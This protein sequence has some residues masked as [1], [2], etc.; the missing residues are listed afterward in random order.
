VEEIEMNTIRAIASAAVLALLSGPALAADSASNSDGS[1]SV[2]WDINAT[3]GAHCAINMSKDPTISATSSN[4]SLSGISG[5]GGTVTIK[6]ASATGTPQAW[7][8][9]ISYGG[10]T[11][12]CNSGGYSLT[13]ASKNGGLAI[14]PAPAKTS[15]GFATTVPYTVAVNFGTNLGTAADASTMKGAGQTLFKGTTAF[16]GDLEIILAGAA[17]TSPLYPG[18][19][20]DT[21]TV[22]LS[23]I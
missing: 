8:A 16:A 11:S 5:S 15:T 20:A 12:S 21:L 22:T 1:A 6:I 13:V 4:A 17:G 3:I 14:S 18:S 9:D 19:Y 7:L 2:G 23:P 10:G